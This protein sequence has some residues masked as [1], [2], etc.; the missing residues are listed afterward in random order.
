MKGK[1][2]IEIG[3][4]VRHFKRETV[5]QS[6]EKYLYEII[7]FAVHTET[8]EPLVIYKAL[9]SPYKVCARP[10]DMFFSLVDKEKYPDIKQKYRFELYDK[11]S[12]L[13]VA[14]A[15]QKQK[16]FDREFEK[17]KKIVSRKVKQQ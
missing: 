2:K 17:S 15:L 4:I 16:D 9:Y 1:R 8:K 11:A 10:Y 3:S 7:S 6:T 12:E 14:K 5:N 13:K